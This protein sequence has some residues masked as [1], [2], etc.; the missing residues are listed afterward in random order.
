MIWTI[1]PQKRERVLIFLV[2][3]LC[4]GGVAQAQPSIPAG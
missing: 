4:Y 3:L 1:I 2:A